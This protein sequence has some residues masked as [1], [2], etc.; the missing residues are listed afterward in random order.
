MRGIGW[1][2]LRA[3]VFLPGVVTIVA[4]SIITW[5]GGAYVGWGFKQP[6]AGLVIA[7]GVLLLAAGIG[8]LAWTIR[9]FARRGQTLAPWDETTQ[10][11]IEGPYRYTRNPMISGVC[12]M[13]LGEAVLI[14]S[15][16][17]AIWFGLFVI[18]Q[19]IFISTGEE[20]GLVKK[21]GEPYRE[22]QRHVPA[23]FPWRRPWSPN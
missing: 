8:M 18:G 12:M 6:G 3:I 21:F 1:R 14:G 17:L 23:V 2:H 16:W 13:L 19:T 7:L 10:L 11:V 20:P 5:L 4:P 22:Y 9:L 15:W